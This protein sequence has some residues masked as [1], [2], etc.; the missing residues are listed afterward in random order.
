MKVDPWVSFP[1]LL[2]SHEKLKFHPQFWTNSDLKH[3]GCVLTG[4][5]IYS[6]SLVPEIL[7]L[8][9]QP[10]LPSFGILLCEKEINDFCG[11]TVICSTSFICS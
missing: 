5:S 4:K 2:A 3:E 6:R 1:F 8:P 7:K 9:Y 11:S 10:C